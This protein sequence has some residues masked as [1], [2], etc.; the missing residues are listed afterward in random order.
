[1]KSGMLAGV[2]GKKTQNTCKI[3]TIVEISF[4]RNIHS[5]LRIYHPNKAYPKRI[6]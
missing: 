2:K 6:L 5:K 4:I 1:M 3:L